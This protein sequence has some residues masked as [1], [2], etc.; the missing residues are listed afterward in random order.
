MMLK[1]SRPPKSSTILHFFHLIGQFSL[2]S[3]SVS[4]SLP[5]CFGGSRSNVAI[6]SRSATLMLTLM[7]EKAE[8]L[9]EIEL[10]N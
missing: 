7:R 2:N 1:Y 5:L 9:D 3:M 10:K 6:E 8:R 4:V